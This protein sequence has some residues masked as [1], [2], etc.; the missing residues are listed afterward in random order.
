MQ[1]NVNFK[2]IK[3]GFFGKCPREPVKYYFADFVRTVTPQN[4]PGKRFPP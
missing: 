1:C 3:V 4:P 2:T